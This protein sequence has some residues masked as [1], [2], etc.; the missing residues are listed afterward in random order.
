MI[1]AMNATRTAIRPA[2]WSAAFLFSCAIAQGQYVSVDSVSNS[3][4]YFDS[5]S[6]DYGIAQGSLMVL[7]GARCRPRDSPFGAARH[8]DPAPDG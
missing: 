5:D 1:S 2:F 8:Q 3:A 4:S 7:Q 6:P